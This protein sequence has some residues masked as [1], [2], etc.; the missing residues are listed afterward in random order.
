MPSRLTRR[1][2][3][4]FS[5][6]CICVCS[7]RRDGETRY[8]WGSVHYTLAALA[9]FCLFSLVSLWRLLPKLIFF[10]L[11]SSQLKSV[12]APEPVEPTSVNGVV[13]RGKR[14][15]PLVL[16]QIKTSLVLIHSLMKASVKTQ[17]ELQ[18]F[19]IIPRSDTPFCLMDNEISG[20]CCELITF[21]WCRR[22]FD[23]QA[24]L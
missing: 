5:G 1:C 4:G 8:L 2:A 10:F 6:S 18:L 22:R 24:S 14:G 15:S 11:L 21:N 17:A 12:F 7:C 9:A 3:V 13:L 23:P 16:S 19:V 20:S